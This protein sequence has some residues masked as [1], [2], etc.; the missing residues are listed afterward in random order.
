[1]L[2]ESAKDESVGRTFTLRCVETKT[3]YYVVKTS[4]KKVKFG[5]VPKCLLSSFG[6][7]LSLNDAS[8]VFQGVVIEHL[9]GIPVIAA[10]PELS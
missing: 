5:I 3:G 2:K 1:M 9:Q 6:I 10:K 4:D 7:N 8:F